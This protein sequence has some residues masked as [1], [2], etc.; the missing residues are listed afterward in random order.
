MERIQVTVRIGRTGQKLH[1][2]TAEVVD[3]APGKPWN[4][5]KYVFIGFGCRCPG[6]QSG[7]ARGK[8]SIV[9][10]GWDHANCGH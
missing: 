2:A 1:R 5:R 7:F 3:S 9:A 4:R 8:V 10:E 6:T